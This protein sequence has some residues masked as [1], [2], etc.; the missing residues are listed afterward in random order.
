MR[1]IKKEIQNVEGFKEK[2]CQNHVRI[3]SS[4]H[5]RKRTYVLQML[6]TNMYLCDWGWFNW[7]SIYFMFF[8]IAMDSYFKIRSDRKYIFFEQMKW[9]NNRLMIYF[10]KHNSDQ[11]G[12][13]KDEARHVYPNSND[14]SICPICALME[15]DCSL[16]K[17]KRNLLIVAYTA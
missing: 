17:I 6:S 13:N 4:C 7:F 10:S 2:Y 14:P 1:G 3:W 15:I 9:G 11:I 8:K 12:W 16:E 5:W